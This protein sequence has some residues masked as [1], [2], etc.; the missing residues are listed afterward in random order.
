ML[1]LFP[2]HRGPH[3]VRGSWNDAKPKTMMRVGNAGTRV[4]K[5][6]GRPGVCEDGDL[7][8]SS[9]PFRWGRGWVRGHLGVE[10][11]LHRRI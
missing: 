8:G 1:V 7:Q 10:S 4:G 6:G 3:L 11:L 2:H 9:C 5:D